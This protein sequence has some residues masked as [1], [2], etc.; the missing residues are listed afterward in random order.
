MTNHGESA[1]S[2]RD[3]AERIGVS[4]ST[5]NRLVAAGQLRAVRIGSRVLIPT[6]EIDR[7]LASG[8]VTR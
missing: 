5:V 4:E 2:K 1:L 7:L 6:S 3:A 8:A